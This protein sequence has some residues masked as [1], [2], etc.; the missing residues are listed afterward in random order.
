MIICDSTFSIGASGYQ[1]LPVREVMNKAMFI[2]NDGTS[3]IL[4]AIDQIGPTEQLLFPFMNFTCDGSLT[5]LMFVASRQRELNK[6][7]IISWPMFFLWHSDEDNSNFQ[8]I[9][10]GPSARNQITS[11]QPPSISS[12]NGNEVEVVMVNFASPIRFVA[13][14]ILGLRQHNRPQT[15]YLSNTSSTQNTTLE[16]LVS[17]SSIRV[18]R[19][20]GGYGL[21]LICDEWYQSHGCPISVR[22]VQEMPYIAIETSKSFEA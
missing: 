14:D 16:P 10:I 2:N 4:S 9:S 1:I 22:R 11:L 19:Q 21:A 6:N 8:L 20:S 13:G 3:P 5:R 18:L 17:D 12:I 15:Q 7:V